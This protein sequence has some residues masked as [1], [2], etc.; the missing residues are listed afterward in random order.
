MNCPAPDRWDLLTARDLSAS[1]EEALRAHAGTC[2]DCTHHLAAVEALKARPAL[3]P[4]ATRALVD[5]VLVA[6]ERPS[7]R[8]P[9]ARLALAAAL[10][11]GVVAVGALLVPRESEWLARGGSEGGWSKRVAAEL[12]P[13]DAVTSPVASNAS[14]SAQGRFAVWYRNAETSQPL[15]LLAYVVDSRGELHWVAPAYVAAG[16]E[17][18]AKVL[19]VTVS[20]SLLP[21]VAELGAPEPG[22]ATLVTVVSR[23][24]GSVLAFEGAPLEQRLHPETLLP[25]AVVWRQTVSLK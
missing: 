21:Q 1:E 12:R 5:R 13:V 15:F 17:P 7:A 19:P 23:A 10:V 8:P 24:P 6:T 9:L 4:A 11:A 22:G 25:G 2:A 18:D 20:E 16:R 3:E 14:L